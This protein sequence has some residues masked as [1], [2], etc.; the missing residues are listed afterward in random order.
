MQLMVIRG[1]LRVNLCGDSEGF[2]CLVPL[3]MVWVDL[4]Y[5]CPL[6]GIRIELISGVKILIGHI[7]SHRV[8]M[9]VVVARVDLQLNMGSSFLQIIIH[10]D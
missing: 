5:P 3:D 1:G 7:A 4:C 6:T 10:R 9:G 2:V 8:I